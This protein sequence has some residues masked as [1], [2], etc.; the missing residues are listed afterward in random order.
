MEAPFDQSIFSALPRR[1]MEPNLRWRAPAMNQPG[2][3][4]NVA[5]NFSEAIDRLLREYFETAPNY[6]EELFERS[7]K[8]QKHVLECIYK[9]L[10]G[11]VIFVR[12]ARKARYTPTSASYRGCQDYWNCP[13]AWDGQ[14][15]RKEKTPTVVQEAICNGQLWIWY[16]H[17]DSP[18]S[19]NDRN[20]LDTSTIM[21]K[22]MK[23]DFPSTLPYDVNGN[24]RTML[25]Y[26]ADGIY[27]S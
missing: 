1:G 8:M 9:G 16:A 25:Y 17:F 4:L 12:C 21:H 3:R 10:E 27:P 24:Y 26:L 7:F 22:R 23:S 13:V 15:K 19:Y 6:V 14:Y 20:V 11:K 5:R 2:K 18:E